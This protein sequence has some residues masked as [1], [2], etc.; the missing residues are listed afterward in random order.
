MDSHWAPYSKWFLYI[1]V[2]YTS[3]VFTYTGIIWRYLPHRRFYIILITPRSHLHFAV[4]RF[5][6]SCNLSSSECAMCTVSSSALLLSRTFFLPTCLHVLP[7][8]IS[9]RSS[10]QHVFIYKY[11]NPLLLNCSCY[12]S[13]LGGICG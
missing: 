5:E 3:G 7:S 4:T 2:P 12:A 11:F 1:T 9:S 10:F 13:H 6:G 8:S